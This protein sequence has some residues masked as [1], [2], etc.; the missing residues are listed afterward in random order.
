MRISAAAVHNYCAL[1]QSQLDHSQVNTSVLAA[2]PEPC[3]TLTHE[4]KVASFPLPLPRDG[5]MYKK[6]KCVA[7][8]RRDPKGT[9]A[10]KMAIDAM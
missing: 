2:S 3:C 9:A 4:E 7:I 10:R 1:F 5:T 8:A 6:S